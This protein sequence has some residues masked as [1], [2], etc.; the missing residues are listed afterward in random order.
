MS[1]NWTLTAS[2]VCDDALEH[3][4]VLADGEVATASQTITALRALNAVL[5]ELP[6]AGFTWP[7]LS[8]E[9]S[10]TWASSQSMTL[11]TDYYG[12]P[13]AWRLS[14][15]QR[16][17]LEQIRHAD[18]VLMTNK[19][20]AGTPTHFYISPAN[21]FL[22]WPTP[23]ADPG[24]TLQY[25]RIVDDAV[26][27]TQP[28]LPQYWLNALG[29]GVA[30]EI[31][32]KFGRDRSTRE[33]IAM[34]WTAKKSLALQNSVPAEIISFEAG[35][36]GGG[37]GS[38]SYGGGTTPALPIATASVLGGI[39]VG[40]GLQI[41]G[42]GVLS[43]A[44]AGTGTV[45][46]V[47]V[48]TANGFAG[49][50]ANPTTTAAITL[51]TSITGLL[52]GNG[53]AM[54]AAV[55]GTDFIVPGGA[56]GTPAS[57]NLANCT[58]P[59]LNQSTTGTASN[60]TGIVL[61]ANGGTGVANSGKTITLGG[62]LTTA[63]AFASTFTMTGATGVTFPTTGTIATLAGAETL[64]SKTLTAPIVTDYTE[65]LY[66]PAAGSAFTINLSN[67]TLQKF[68]TNANCTLTLPSSVA[69]K[70]YTVIVAY[71]GVHTLAWAGGS[72]IKWSGGAAPAA[73]SSSGKFDFFVF[74]CD[75]TNT[76]GRSG[77]ANF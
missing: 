13:V 71:G 34:R 15:G 30:N 16:L 56:L 72:T 42:L 27:G 51:T 14:G 45:T 7:K 74:T 68:T 48:A 2:Q 9:V 11:P 22:M 25:Q 65:T 33:E 35:G 66:A 21:V 29:Y 61:G 50:V 3:L 38:Q 49:S 5:K 44:G 59:T 8:A 4:G 41:T 37:Y 17:P 77:G 53:T 60:V 64:S 20:A 18:W 39:M 70:S 28:D 55:A 76:Y 12:N 10:L 63:G 26:S 24:I 73:T 46:T 32:L 31:S 58:F 40:A 1:T 52:K 62:N 67:G 54:S 47:S 75:G 57:G 36:Y 69:G 6:L 23:T 43:I 19:Q